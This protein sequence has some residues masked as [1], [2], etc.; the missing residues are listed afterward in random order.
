MAGFAVVVVSRTLVLRLKLCNC[1][2]RRSLNVFEVNVAKRQC[3]LDAQ[4]K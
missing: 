4:R 1:R 3:K 2:R